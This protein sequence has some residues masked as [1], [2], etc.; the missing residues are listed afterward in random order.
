MKTRFTPLVKVKKDSMQKCE[1]EF[2]HSSRLLQ[3]AESTLQQA[4]EALNASSTPSSGEVSQLLR[5]RTLIEVQRGI[6]ER[7]RDEAEAAQTALERSREALRLAMLE[8]EKFK[9]LEAEQ[10]KA[11][12]QKEKRRQQRELDEIA[13]QNYGLK[14]G[15][16]AEV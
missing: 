11:A 3:L 14:K 5:S 8:Y 16:D 7:C 15:N 12:L 13:V 4:I 9:Y 2:Q 1:R 10:I 6:V